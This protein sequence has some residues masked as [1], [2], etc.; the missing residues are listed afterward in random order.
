MKIGNRN[1]SGAKDFYSFITCWYDC[2]NQRLIGSLNNGCFCFRYIKMTNINVTKM[3]FC[4]CHHGYE[5]LMVINATDVCFLAKIP[6]NVRSDL[7]V[8]S[9]MD[10]MNL[11]FWNCICARFL[12]SE[13]KP[14]TYIT[15][16]D[17]PR[18]MRK[19]NYEYFGGTSESFRK[20]LAPFVIS[21]SEIWLV[22]DQSH[23]FFGLK[24]LRS[25]RPRM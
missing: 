17:S 20:F 21:N 9:L 24:N 3:K 11:T 25:L 14:Q 6:Q 19:L 7:F 2:A 4:Y 5:V 1:S 23:G 18:L 10:L 8:C 16:C 13:T 12:P 22:S 15:S